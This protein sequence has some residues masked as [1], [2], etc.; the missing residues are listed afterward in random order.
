[1]EAFGAALA[2]LG[3]QYDL[4]LVDWWTKR[5]LDLRNPQD[6]RSYLAGEA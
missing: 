4:V 3:K 6:I 2:Q 5:V 1:L